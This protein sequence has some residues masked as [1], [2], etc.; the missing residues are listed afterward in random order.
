MSLSYNKPLWTDGEGAEINAARLQ[1]IS[2]VLDGLINQIGT[3]S[4]VDIIIS[5][6]TMTMKYADGTIEQ[7]ENPTKGERG[8]PGSDGFSP[9][10][11]MYEVKSGI[12][13]EITDAEG[14]HIG[15]IQ[16]GLSPKLTETQTDTGYDISIED[17]RGERTIS[18]LNGADGFSPVLAETATDDG[19]NI[20]ITDAEGTRTISLT[21]GKDGT[22]GTSLTATH[23]KTGLI[24]TVEIKNAETGEV[25]DTFQIADGEASI[26]I[27]SAD[28]LGGIKVGK[29][30]T[31]TPDGT[32]DAEAGGGTDV[33]LSVVDGKICI[34]YEE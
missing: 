11:D 18:L 7:I 3:K 12:N 22:D 31:I 26:P 28:V 10:V 15:F 23:T 14:Q 8:E 16:H 20:T 32:L 17:Q 33:G 13:L 19:Y 34:T 29:N 21:N 24:T 30:L 27:A 2:N 6:E 25:I 5:G 4:V 1:A 9:L